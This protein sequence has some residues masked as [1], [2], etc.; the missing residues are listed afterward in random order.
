MHAHV[1]IE[2]RIR[3]R[4]AARASIVPAYYDYRRAMS[5]LIRRGRTG[6]WI[7]GEGALGT[8]RWRL[9]GKPGRG[10]WGWVAAQSLMKR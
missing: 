5:A 9:M 8:E 6:L 3:G 2:A 7:L 1:E 10:H 4:R